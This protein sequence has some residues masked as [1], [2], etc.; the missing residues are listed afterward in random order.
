MSKPQGAESGRS[1]RHN[2]TILA[3]V[4]ASQLFNALTSYIVTTSG[5]AQQARDLMFWLPGSF[6][7]VRWPDFQLLTLVVL[8]GLGSAC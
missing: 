4:A 2:H 3:G 7:G 1:L 8:V 6:G 5:N